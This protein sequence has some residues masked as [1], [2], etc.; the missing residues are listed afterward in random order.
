MNIH[1]GHVHTPYCPHGTKDSLAAYCDEAIRLGRSGITFAE[2]APL[3]TSFIDPTPDQD[4][5]MKQSELHTY[6]DEIQ[7]LKK[8]YQNHLAIYL[9]LEVD[10]IIGFET[11]TKAFLEEYGPYLDDSILSVHFIQIG[12]QY[13]CLDYSPDAFSLICD[14]LGSIDAVHRL[15]YKTVYESVSAELG[16]YK[17]QRIGHMTLVQKFHKRFRTNT[18]HLNQI[19][20]ILN[21]IKAKGYMLDYNGAGVIKPL[22]KEPYPYSTVIHQAKQMNIPLVYGSDAHQVKELNNG[23]HSLEFHEHLLTSATLNQGR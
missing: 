1:D 17:P 20:A 8:E 10:F 12:D 15:Y 22:C 23:Y 2:H 4:S 21:K 9:G 13:V 7:Q 14:Q 5:A 18:S 19:T 6:I 11:E 16:T 3:P